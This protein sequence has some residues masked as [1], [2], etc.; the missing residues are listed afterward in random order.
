[1]LNP[2]VIFSWNFFIHKYFTACVCE[3]VYVIRDTRN[4]SRRCIIHVR[5]SSGNFLQQDEKFRDAEIV[6]ITLSRRL[7]KFSE[8]FFSFIFLQ[9]VDLSE[10]VHLGIPHFHFGL[11]VRNFKIIVHAAAAYLAPLRTQSNDI[12]A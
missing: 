6:P 2:L 8:F 9:R 10:W 12:Y 11:V 4:Y 7:L 3:W 5:F 1:M